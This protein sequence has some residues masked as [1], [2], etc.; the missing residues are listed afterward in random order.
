MTLRM[1]RL[2]RRKSG[3]WGARITIPKDVRP[4][5]QALYGKRAE[6]LFYAPPDCTPQ[7]APVLFSQWQA[8]IK[9]R[10]D[11]LRRKQRGEGHDL[12]QRDA[13]ALAGEWYKWFVGRHEENP[14]EA[15][16][17]AKLREVLWLLLEDVAGDPE[18]GEIDFEAPDVRE[19]IHPKLADEAT[20]A[21]FLASKGEVLTPAAM[22]GFLDAVLHEF[23]EA[24]A[25][26]ERRASRDY[27]SDRHLQTLPEYRRK[28]APRAIAPQGRSSA[29]RSG[30]TAMQL[31]EHYI[32]ANPLADGTVR[33][34]HTVFAALDASLAGRDFDSLSDDEA[35][36][37]VTALV[38]TKKQ[39]PST[40]MRIW[41]TAL[42]AVGRWAIK[43]K[44]I[45]RNPFADCDVAVPKRTRN[46]E[47]DAF[48]TDEIKLILSS[49]SAIK[50]TR[51]PTPA[52]RRWVP[53]ICA[54]TG[55]RAGEITQLRG[56]D[57]IEQDGIKAIRITPEA[58]SV[59]T[60]QAR[61]VPI[62]E[63]LIAERF[64]DYVKVKGKGPLFYNPPTAADA[65][66][67]D[68]TN[69]PK[70]SRAVDARSRLGAWIR[71]IGITDKEVSPTHGWRHTFKQIADR[72]GISDRVSDV[73]TGHTPPTEGRKYGAPT[74]ED[75]AE[76]LKKFPR[77]KIEDNQ[78]KQPQRLQP[79]PRVSEGTE[80]EAEQ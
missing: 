49:A 74:L 60:G 69:P 76:A 25:L 51:T 52:A 4:D 65:T 63:H 47:T 77:Y 26:L 57:V 8:D 1:A 2:R 11:T 41:V 9:N 12:T 19:E 79:T 56:Q 23:L 55:A 27:S 24:T 66:D 73:I 38:T 37:W 36:E 48:K 3:A 7:R 31:F 80:S 6:E 78:P 18:T 43:R 29:T 22:T 33:R 16:R 64:L 34:W 20:T 28:A 67:I 61:M 14:G 75:M 13:H 59:K 68:V 32:A 5:Y 39:S 30:K 45:T 15:N 17:W 70:R 46:R 58:G 53:W 62:H 50:N 44:R 35:Q 21:Q 54:Y 10:I 40:V 71:S 42:K 72:N